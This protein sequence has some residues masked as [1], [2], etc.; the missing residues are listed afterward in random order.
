MQTRNLLLLAGARRGT[1][2]G[3]GPAGGSLDGDERRTSAETGVLGKGLLVGGV[4][5]C[6]F[7]VQL[8]GDVCRSRGSRRGGGSK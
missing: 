8:D 2:P 4:E 7:R 6:E 3:I 5:T 1:C